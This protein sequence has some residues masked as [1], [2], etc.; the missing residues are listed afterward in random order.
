MPNSAAVEA[1]V[2]SLADSAK[3]DIRD[4][5]TAIYWRLASRYSQQLHFFPA[6]A[7]VGPAGSGKGTIMA[8][9]KVMPGETSPITDC[10]IITMAACRDMLAAN[11][12]RVFFADECDG[13]K[14][15]VS[16]LFMARTNR[17]MAEITYKEQVGTN[18]K[19]EQ[20]TVNIFGPTVM[21]LRNQLDDPAKSSRSIQIFT[22]HADGPYPVFDADLSALSM[23]EFDMMHI[24]TT[25]GRVAV[26]W[27]PVLAIA[28]QLGDFE[29][30]ADIQALISM[31]M[32][33]LRERAEY[34]PA[35]VVLARIV[36]YICSQA[37]ATRWDRIDIDGWIGRPLRLDYPL[38]NPLMVSNVISSLGFVT[39]R[40]GG[41][42]WLWA[43]PET[44]KLAALK[45]HYKD[46][47]LDAILASEESSKQHL[48]SLS[49][50]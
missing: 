46:T 2:Y 44:L 49:L 27:A 24:P 34:D 20:R 13:L 48:N 47:E 23:L 39:E 50:S 17:E 25:G 21:H 22:R 16:H 36:D 6:L 15:E 38:L 14:P 12:N 18:N 5:K 10:E 19:Y 3:L 43:T 45:R 37:P 42:R 35:S 4:A 29:Y 26:T 32:Q 9:L 33:T 40:R 41:R 7:L 8:A 31:E 30:L 11:Q 1:A 28:E